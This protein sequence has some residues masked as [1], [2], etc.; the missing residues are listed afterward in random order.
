MII[1]RVVDRTVHFSW[2]AL[3]LVPGP[4]GTLFNVGKSDHFMRRRV[5]RNIEKRKAHWD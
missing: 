5:G 2:L 4:I 1:P 3:V